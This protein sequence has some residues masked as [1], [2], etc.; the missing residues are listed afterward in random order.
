MGR[1]PPALSTDLEFEILH[2]I[3]WEEKN[4]T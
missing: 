2:L 3:N 1:K 4:K